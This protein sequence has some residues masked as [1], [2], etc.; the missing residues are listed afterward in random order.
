MNR[1]SKSGSRITDSC[2]ST[3]SNAR[4]A[5]SSVSVDCHAVSFFRSD[6]SGVANSAKMNFQ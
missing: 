4:K 2:W 1:L 6:F 3:A 5:C